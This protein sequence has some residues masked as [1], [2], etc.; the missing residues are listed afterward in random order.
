MLSRGPCCC[1]TG[2]TLPVVTRNKQSVK[3]M[4]PF[5]SGR[6]SSFI[7]SFT[8]A[9]YA[10]A[11]RRG[12]LSLIIYWRKH[13]VVLRDEHLRRLAGAVADAETCGM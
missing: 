12:W 6:H 11:V 10:L 13:L 3:Q 8:Y 9:Q 2:E 1:G 4:A 5:A 7:N